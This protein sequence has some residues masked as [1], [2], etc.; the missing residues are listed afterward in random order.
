MDV[1]PQPKPI[2][3]SEGRIV[4]LSELNQARLVE[5]QTCPLCKRGVMAYDG[6]LV[7]RC[8]VCGYHG[9]AGCFT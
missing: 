9:D 2:Q 1:E 6:M 8:S 5:G 7:L 4:Y 3:D